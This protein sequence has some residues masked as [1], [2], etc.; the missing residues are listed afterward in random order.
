M[1]TCE[2]VNVVIPPIFKGD[3]AAFELEVLLA[4]GKKM[5]FNGKTVKFIVKKDRHALDETAIIS[6]TYTPTQDMDTLFIL[7]SKEETNVSP[8]VYQF[9]IRIIVDG[10]QTTEG[11]G[12]LEIKQ[13]PFYDN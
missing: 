6:K 1:I 4:T 10:V 8:G 12:R 9:G 3:D 7:L 11:A 13:G 2:H 5:N